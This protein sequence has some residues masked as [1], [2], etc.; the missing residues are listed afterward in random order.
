MIG[1]LVIGVF[2]V[3]TPE[4]GGWQNQFVHTNRSVYKYHYYNFV[5]CDLPQIRKEVSLPEFCRER[6]IVG[7]WGDG[8]TTVI[9]LDNESKI[10]FDVDIDPFGE[11]VSC[12]RII[13]FVAPGASSLEECFP[14]ND[15][16][17]LD[18]LRV[19]RR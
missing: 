16:E 11:Q 8:E 13:D 5:E 14:T 10:L 6:V 7:A 17:K 15:Y 12:Y 2:E 9:V 19:E 18:V 4:D 1:E 3:I